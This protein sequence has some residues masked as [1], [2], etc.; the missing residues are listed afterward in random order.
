M[1]K[2]ACDM[3]AAHSLAQGRGGGENQGGREDPLP[4]TPGLTREVPGSESRRK[5][6][7]WGGREADRGG[8]GRGCKEQERRGQEEEVKGWRKRES[9]V[10][11]KMR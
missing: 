2:G 9:T 6:A 10:V 3:R 8:E 11:K 1:A 5:L 4:S 7:C